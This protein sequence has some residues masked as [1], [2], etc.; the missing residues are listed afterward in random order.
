M[1]VARYTLK[2]TYKEAQHFMVAEIQSA[3][4]PPLI[5]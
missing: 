2:S 1:L 4:S 5:V 3:L